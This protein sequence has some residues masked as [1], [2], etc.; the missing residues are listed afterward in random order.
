MDSIFTA[1]RLKNISTVFSLSFLIALSFFIVIKEDAAAY[2][3]DKD[4]TGNDIIASDINNMI[5]YPHFGTPAFI[6]PGQTVTAEV[7]ASEALGTGGWTAWVENDLRKWDCVVDSVQ[8]GPNKIYMNTRTGYTVSI[9]VPAEISPELCTLVLKHSSGKTLRS[10]MSVSIV[11]SL[12]TNFYITT[13]TDTHIYSFDNNTV[14]GANSGKALG[15]LA[16]ASTLAGSRF[17][18]HTGDVCMSGYVSRAVGIRDYMMTP[19]CRYGRVPLIF[20]SGNHEYDTYVFPAP[21]R[22]SGQRTGDFFYSDNDRYFG[23]RSRIINMGSFIV[24]KHDFGGYD[25]DVSLRNTLATKWNQ[26]E[27]RVKYRLL[28]QHDYNSQLAF[29]NPYNHKP[30]PTPYPDLELQGDDHTYSVNQ[31]SPFKVFCNGGGE[32]WTFG[33][34]VLYNFNRDNGGNWTCPQSSASRIDFIKDCRKGYESTALWDCYSRPNNGNAVMN[35]CTVTN[36]ID[37]N[38]FDGRVRFLM[39]QGNYDVSGGTILSQYDYEESDGTWHTA[40]LVDVDIAPMSHTTILITP[41]IRCSYKESFN[42]CI[43]GTIPEGWALNTDGGFVSVHSFPAENNKSLKLS[44]QVIPDYTTASRMFTPRSSGLILIDTCVRT[45]DTGTT[46]YLPS[47]RDSE[48]RSVAKVSF[49]NGNIMVNDSIKVQTF[50]ASKWYHILVKVNMSA[51]NFEL[52]IDDVYK[53]EYNFL[54]RRARNVA[55][56]LYASPPDSPSTSYI[57]SCRVYY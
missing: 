23:M 49:S 11:P 24:A 55:E 10:P 57:N 44:K 6:E 42:T 46:K 18:A 13:V 40:V 1:R 8:Y 48:K 53:G 16:G 26:L 36:D 29:F 34:A 30:A 4:I 41:S 54:N 56:V 31:T 14:D 20:A 22:I 5:V 15:M 3:H 35:T 27:G 32:P 45:E 21:S 50:E 7:A 52:Y 25:G 33:A 38:F 17:L 43:D 28:L 19:I 37:F 12:E 47:I 9:I 51:G 2:I 39:E